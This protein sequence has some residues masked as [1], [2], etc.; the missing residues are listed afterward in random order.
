M[1]Y[2]S[3]IITIIFILIAMQAK[4]GAQT[5]SVAPTN[6]IPTR[7]VE[8]Q[9]LPDLHYARSAHSVFCIG[10]ELLAVGGHTD[11]FVP[12]QT[13]EYFS[14]GEW[15]IINTIYTHDAGVSA[16]LKSG[17]LLFAGGFAEALGIG[18]TF[19]AEM[20][21][22]ETHTFVGFGCLDK[23]R[24]GASAETLGN[25]KVIVSGNWYNDDFIEEYNGN[26]AFAPLK[27]PHNGL[28][29]PYI[30]PI[31]QS[32]ALILGC[33][34]LQGKMVEEPYVVERLQGDTFHVEL[35]KTWHP[36]FKIL[37]HHTSDCFIGDTSRGD[38]SYLFPVERKDGQVG[39]CL[40]QGERFTLVKT[41]SPLP[42]RTRWGVLYYNSGMI[43]DPKSCRAY[44]PAFDNHHNRI[45][46][47]AIDYKPA[48]SGKPAPVTLYYT[49]ELSKVG[50]TMTVLTP[51]GDLCFVGGLGESNYNPY[52]SVYVLKVGAQ[53]A[54]ESTHNNVV[55]W[56]LLAGGV[57]VVVMLVVLL[58]LIRRRKP[59]TKANDDALLMQ[60]LDE[61][62]L[63]QQLF[64]NPDL[65]TSDVAS[66]LGVSATEV[67]A[68]LRSQRALT[69]INYI[70]TCRIDYVKQQLSDDSDIKVVYL[71]TK[72]GFA[73]EA[74]FFRVFK[75][76][77]GMSP[78]EWIAQRNN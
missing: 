12:T 1:R 26:R 67:T 4:V 55:K 27:K 20:Y 54:E 51:E 39:V 76:Q 44:L 57:V 8:A 72:A 35:F 64:R 3:R 37:R 73:S 66:A 53:S 45:F 25:G 62:M 63:S 43:T 15:H 75:A 38:Y 77:T 19:P 21:D 61:L 31:S 65:K 69:F 47:V 40:L 48:L 34:G 74:T 60:R 78:K 32:N 30:F 6:A 16:R 29:R 2:C 71:W 41:T 58:C 7:L 10:D 24:T 50:A 14:K 49:K 11:G 46:V 42:M 22:P 9:R 23:K 68:A 17:K 18:Q 70:N 56:W 13:A 36:L 52:K 28:S 33:M 5:K 59:K